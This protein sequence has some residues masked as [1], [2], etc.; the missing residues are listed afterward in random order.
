MVHQV[1]K[2]KQLRSG[3]KLYP[4]KLFIGILVCSGKKVMARRILSRLFSH[5]RKKYKANPLLFLRIFFERMRP[6]V[7][8][9]SK[10][11][12]G[13]THKIPVPVSYRKSI[14]ILLHWWVFA[15]KKSSKGHPFAAALIHE[16]DNSYKLA[17]SN[18]SKKRDEV[19]RLAH[20]NRPFLRYLKFLFLIPT[21]K[22]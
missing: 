16:L 3:F 2:K 6:K 1:V 14:S 4:Y 13:V 15:A 18:L 10:K 9:Y 19:H 12:A 11:I 20:L 17:S 7:S 5:I 8:L 21:T 22:I